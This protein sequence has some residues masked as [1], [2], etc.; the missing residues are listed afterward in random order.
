MKIRR[1]LISVS[2]KNGLSTFAQGL[3]ELGV[4]LISTSG[5]SAFLEAAGV[6]V[7]TVEQLTGSAELLGGRV[8]TLHASLHAAIL[9]R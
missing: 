2:E 5:T 7:T 1:A 4:E 3:H 8:K 6:P 9:A